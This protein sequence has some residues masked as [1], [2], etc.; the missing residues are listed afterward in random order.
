MKKLL[1][2][3]IT[4]TFMLQ[5]NAQEG[6][7][8]FGAKAG[9][10]L[11]TLNGD[12]EGAKGRTSFHLGGMA[13]IPITNKLSIQPELL[14]SSQGAKTEGATLVFNYLNVPVMAKYYVTNEL[15]L[16][17]G[18][19][20]GYLLSANLKYE[21]SGDNNPG[22]NTTEERSST[23][24]AEKE[25]VKD[26]VKSIDFGINFGLGYK[27][28]NGLNFGL[29]YNLGLANANNF[30]NSSQE[31]KNGVFQISVGYFFL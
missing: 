23:K 25:D 18:P 7:I 14:F 16:E 31:F 19:Q 11:T 20:I 4:L 15:S 8:Q 28:E 6:T 12:I 24:A 26:D 13:E 1:L 5:A 21:T 27:M 29:R 10:N 22:P 9:L 30:E 3:I 17:A 2:S